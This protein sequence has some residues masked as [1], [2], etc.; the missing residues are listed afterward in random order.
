MIHHCKAVKAGIRK[1]FVIGDMPF[2]SYEQSSEHA[3]QNATRLM[4]EGRM[5][6]VKLEGGKKIAP[7]IEAIV[8][9]GG[10]NVST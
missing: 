1:T 6:A 2:G 8:N 4:K 3:L 10:E 5:D 9:A 7:R